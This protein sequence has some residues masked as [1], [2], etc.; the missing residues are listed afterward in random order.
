MYQQ[1]VATP[2]HWLK[3]K[4]WEKFFKEKFRKIKSSKGVDQRLVVNQHFESSTLTL[5]DL[6]F[7]VFFDLSLFIPFV[8]DKNVKTP[9]KMIRTCERHTKHLFAG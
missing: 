7:E 6:F 1:L 5:V 3:P 8:A 2:K 4:R 9:K